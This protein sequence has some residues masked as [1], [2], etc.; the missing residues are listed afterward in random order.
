MK[1]TKNKHRGRP[2]I[3]PPEDHKRL[4]T[5]TTEEE[6]TAWAVAA[7]MAARALGLPNLTIGPWSRMVL[8]QAARA[9]GVEIPDKD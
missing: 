7:E 3:H 9:L 6:Y 5:R 2:A 8:N 4:M 1:N